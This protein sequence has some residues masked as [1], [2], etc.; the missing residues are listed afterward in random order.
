MEKKFAMLMG[1][2]IYLVFAIPELYDR[3]IRIF[4]KGYFQD[5]ELR[6]DIFYAN[7]LV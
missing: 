3:P 7:N 4:V 2:I 1:Y 5:G 6:S